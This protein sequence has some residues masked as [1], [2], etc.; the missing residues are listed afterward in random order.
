MAKKK[1]SSK[2][3]NLS[4]LEETFEYAIE[5]YK[6]DFKSNKDYKEEIKL[7]NKIDNLSNLHTKPKEVIIQAGSI[8]DYIIPVIKESLENPD[9]EK[10]EKRLINELKNVK[11]IQKI[12][13]S[14]DENLSSKPQLVAKQ[15]MKVSD[16]EDELEKEEENIRYISKKLNETKK[17]LKN[18]KDSKKIVKYK[19]EIA[20]LEK[21]LKE[22]KENLIEIERILEK[23]SYIPKQLIKDLQKLQMTKK[24]MEE[25]LKGEGYTDEQIEEYLKS[26]DFEEYKFENPKVEPVAQLIQDSEISPVYWLCKALYNDEEK[27][28]DESNDCFPVFSMEEFENH[29]KYL[30]VPKSLYSEK[31]VTLEHIINN[32]V[33]IVNDHKNS[34]YDYL[35]N[36]KSFDTSDEVI[37]YIKKEFHNIPLEQFPKEIDQEKEID[38]Q[39]KEI[40]IVQYFEEWLVKHDI[41]IPSK[42]R[43]EES[44]ARLFGREYYDLEDKVLRIIESDVS[45]ESKVKDILAEFDE[46]LIKAKLKQKKMP[47]SDKELKKIIINILSN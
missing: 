42:D 11:E 47:S 2:K 1:S 7:T 18:C 22:A 35:F 31:N 26:E 37:D 34:E 14:L 12:I 24:E 23:K 13:N 44:E 36:G 15:V 41:T 28:I 25:F 5:S 30:Q 45:I 29:K 3:P 8:M 20:S 16:Y 40:D 10:E 6:E 17:S 19:R 33:Q 43:K 4:K 27:L 32:Y 9:D 21:K 46:V 39:Q 38:S